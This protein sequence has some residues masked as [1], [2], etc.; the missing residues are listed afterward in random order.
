MS[1]RQMPR[2][3]REVQRRVLQQ[4]DVTEH[5]RCDRC[6]RLVYLSDWSERDNCCVDCVTERRA[7]S[8]QWDAEDA[9]PFLPSDEEN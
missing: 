5:P 3:M 2:W 8:D 7:V 6:G 9:K 1:P 4:P